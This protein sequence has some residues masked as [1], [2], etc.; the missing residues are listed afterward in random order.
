MQLFLG[1]VPIILRLFSKLEDTYYS[2]IIPGIICQ[3]LLNNLSRST[4]NDIHFF[5]P[6]L[7]IN[8][9]K[10]GVKYTGVRSRGAGGAAAPLHKMA[11][12]HPSP[13]VPSVLWCNVYV[14]NMFYMTLYTCRQPHAVASACS[15]SGHTEHIWLVH[16]AIVV[17]QNIPG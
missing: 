8:S 17:I 1:T 13:V 10:K 3:S 14:Y 7:R 6:D 12:P 16:A 5:Q 2:Q 9:E 11:K 15:Y 4:T